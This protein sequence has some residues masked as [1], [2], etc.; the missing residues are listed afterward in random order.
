MPP[1]GT[2]TPSDGSGT[3]ASASGACPVRTRLYVADPLAAG[4][5]IGLKPTQAHYLRHVLRLA[6]GDAVGLFNGEDGEWLARIA[7]FG[8]GWA[9]LDVEAQLRPQRAEPDLWLAFAPIK[10][11][12]IDY[13]AQKASELGASRVQPVMTA[14]TNVA[15]V[16]TGRLAANTVEA[17]QQTGR[18]TVPSVDDPCSFAEF[19][20]EFAAELRAAGAGPAAEGARRL[21]VC[22]ETG[23]GLP[24]WD[25]LAPFRASSPAPWAV[26]IGPEGGFAPDELDALGNLPFV[27]RV[28]LGP[29]LLRADTAAVAALAC[30]QAILGDW[31]TARPGS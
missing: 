15:R 9:S 18:L 10:H 16:N 27:T 7:G 26:L 22:D 13:L 17:A 29:R 14:Y 28:S 21:M 1:S 3:A 6:A 20:A 24:V 31:A 2:M 8:K 5:S 19:A 4:I 23:K 12:R 25:A 30:W 11:G